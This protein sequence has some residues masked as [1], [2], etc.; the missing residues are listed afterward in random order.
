M[1]KRPGEPDR[2]LADITKI[3][4]QFNW[5]PKISINKGIAML[6]KNTSS[7]KDA[8]VWTPETIKKAT[9]NWFKFLGKS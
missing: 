4:E 3:M 8:P 6:L 1:P 2:S 9:K 5:R 7:W